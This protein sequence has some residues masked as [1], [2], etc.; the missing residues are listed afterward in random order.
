LPTDLATQY[1][2]T[3]FMLKSRSGFDHLRDL[4]GGA[5]YANAA[6][7]RSVTSKNR[8][9]FDRIPAMRHRVCQFSGDAC[10]FP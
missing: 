5:A 2:I 7:R 9:E 4:S 8:P 3:T 6:S 10:G 1:I